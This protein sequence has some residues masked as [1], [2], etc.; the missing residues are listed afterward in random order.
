MEGPTPRRQQWRTV[1]DLNRGKVLDKWRDNERALQRQDPALASEEACRLNA[2]GERLD[3]LD[4]EDATVPSA[5]PDFTLLFLFVILFYFLFHFI[6]LF[7]YF[8]S[9]FYFYYYYY[10]FILFFLFV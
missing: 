9:L 6:L 1:E 7:Y 2:T 10:Y 8:I 4:E 5:E 3:N